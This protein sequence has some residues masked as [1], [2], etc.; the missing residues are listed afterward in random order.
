[1]LI[2]LFALT[3]SILKP[4]SLYEISTRPYLYLLG[5]KLGKTVTLRDIPESEFDDWKNKGFE[6]VWFMGVWQV[7]DIGLKH[8]RETDNLKNSYNENLPGWN[9]DDVIGSPYAIV[10]YT[11]NTAIGTLEDIAWIREELHKR[12]MKLMLDFVPNHSALD[13]PEVTS[14]VNFYIRAPNGQVSSS[15]YWNNGI[16]FGC[17]KWC[18]PWTDVAQYNYFDEGLRQH[19]IDVLKFIASVADGARCDMAHLIISAQFEDYWRN[20]LNAYG[21]S[22]PSREFWEEAISTV[23]SSYPEFRFLAES[24]SDNE[25]NLINLGFDFAYD[26]VPYDKLTYKDAPGFIQEIWNRNR[27]YKSHCCFFTENHDEKRAVAN[28][29]YNYQAAN[30]AAGALLTLPGMRFFN[31]EQ[32]NGPSNKIDVHL[33]RANYEQPNQACVTFYDKLFQV[34]K[35][36]CMTQGEFTQLNVDGSNSIAAWKY[37]Y[38]DEHVLVAVN[39]A[40]NQAGGWIKISD[41]PQ[42]S[43]I[44]VL[45]MI[46]GETYYRDG[47]ELRNSGIFVLLNQYQV[48]IFKY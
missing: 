12:G 34:L 25:A 15:K 7:G 46:S 2:L 26:K 8:D 37:S 30:A 17:G 13:A 38:G 23:K 5:Q 16:A 22:R 31:Q 1:M 47:N 14:K 40:D 28:F 35:L 44:P 29:F 18:D 20:E 41:A 27:D 21:Y 33:R 45:E 24:Y 9:N 32:W 19:Q 6:W 43:N 39:F 48:Q 11:V 3:S 36:E 10:Q 42:G 4:T